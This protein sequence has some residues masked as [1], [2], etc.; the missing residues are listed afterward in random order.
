MITNVLSDPAAKLFTYGRNT[1]LVLKDHPAASKTGTTDNNR[2]AWTDGYTT[3]LAIVGWAGSTD[4]HPM[5]QALPPLTA[6]KISLE[7]MQASAAALNPPAEDCPR[8]GGL[9]V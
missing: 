4:A 1:P 7:A 8:P 5:K 3:N 2:D 6:G 9:A